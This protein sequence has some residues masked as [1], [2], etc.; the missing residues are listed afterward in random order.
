MSYPTARI[1]SQQNG[2]AVVETQSQP[3]YRQMYHIPERDA[4]KWI[5]AKLEELRAKVRPSI[6]YVHPVLSWEERWGEYETEEYEP[7]EE[8]PSQ[9]MVTE[10][11]NLFLPENESKQSTVPQVDDQPEKE[12]WTNVKRK[13]RFRPVPL[14]DWSIDP[15]GMSKAK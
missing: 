1:T 11:D 2:V 6:P 10:Y 14:D 12:G 9:T 8:L 15:P 3:Y 5:Q 13:F 7:E 4:E